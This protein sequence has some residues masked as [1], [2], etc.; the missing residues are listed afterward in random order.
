MSW[1]FGLGGFQLQV[2]NPIQLR[3]GLAQRGECCGDLA[4]VVG[5]VVEHVRQRGRERQRLRHAFQGFVVQ[6]AV[7]TLGGVWVNA[8]LPAIIPPAI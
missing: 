2:I 4:P 3:R 8:W 5:G 6:L 1:F 7:K